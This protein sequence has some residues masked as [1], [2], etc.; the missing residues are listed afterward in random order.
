[1]SECKFENVNDINVRNE[2]NERNERNSIEILCDDV[3]LIV[4]SYLSLSEKLRYERVCKRWQR[5]M[6]RN[7]TVIKV[8][9]NWEEPIKQ[10]IIERNNAYKINCSALE[11]VLKK[12]PN[13]HAIEIN[14]CT[15]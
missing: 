2:R 1:M 3:L 10:L 6:W 11:R 13:I 9:P 7:Q 4:L 14:D 12:C 8:A 5:L 15:I